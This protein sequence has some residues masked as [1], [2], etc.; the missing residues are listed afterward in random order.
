MG[1]V[2]KV[3][4][5]WRID[6]ERVVPSFSLIMRGVSDFAQTARL[7]IGIVAGSS[8]SNN[9]N[10]R[11]TVALSMLAGIAVG[12]FG[13]QALHAQAKPKAYVVI[14]TEVLDEAAFKEF[15]PKVAEANK[16][17]GGSF[18]ARGGR[19]A[20]IDGTPPKRATIQMFDS[21]DQAKDYRN[22]PAWKAILELQKKATKTRSFVVEGL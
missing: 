2:L 21:F 5:S 12:A 17:A 18:L 3:R 13:L 22:S 6:H 16:A 7:S 19:I 20:A 14:E 10:T 1:Y 9:M 15:L 8:G 4:H 11:Y